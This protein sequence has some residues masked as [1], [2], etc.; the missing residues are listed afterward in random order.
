MFILWILRFFVFHLHESPKYLMGR[1]RD[2]EA[3]EV[4]KRV[5]IFNQRED[6]VERL[7]ANHLRRAGVLAGGKSEKDDGA[8]MDT[9]VLGVIKR[10]AREVFG[11][12]HLKGLFHTRKMVWNTSL[13]ILIWGESTFSSLTSNALTFALCPSQ[14]G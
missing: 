8:D 13:L 4:M 6:M 14:Q 7:T 10:K 12:Q 1:G 11:A 2:E 3:V 5:A 9:S